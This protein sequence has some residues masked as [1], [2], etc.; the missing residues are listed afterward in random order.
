LAPGN[1]TP[2]N[3]IG[4]TAGFNVEGAGT[5]FDVLGQ[6]LNGSINSAGFGFGAQFGYQYWDSKYY[7]SGR[8]Y[9]DYDTIPSAVPGGFNTGYVHTMEVACIGANL[10]GSTAAPPVPPASFPQSLLNQLTAPC[11]ALGLDQRWGHHQ[12]TVAG[13]KLQYVLASDAVLDLGYYHVNYND[14]GT[15]ATGVSAPTDQRVMIE[16]NKVFKP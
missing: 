14:N 9:L 15:V 13:G 4:I 6:G 1:C 11:L 5:N 16:F 2:Q 8:L 7:L 3:C 12:G 10:F